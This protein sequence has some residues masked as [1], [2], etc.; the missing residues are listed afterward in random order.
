MVALINFD[1]DEKN[2]YA[3]IYKMNVNL[4]NKKF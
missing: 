1:E 2:L 4:K 3:K